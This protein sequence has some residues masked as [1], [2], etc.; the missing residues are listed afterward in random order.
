MY[1][2]SDKH[3]KPLGHAL[4]LCARAPTVTALTESSRYR[5]H[6]S[7]AASVRGVRCSPGPARRGFPF[8]CFC[9]NPGVRFV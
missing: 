3:E 8:C 6:P 4:L 2:P 9:T 7:A 5:A 1:F